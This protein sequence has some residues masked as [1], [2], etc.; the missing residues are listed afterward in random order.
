MHLLRFFSFQCFSHFCRLLHVAGRVA[1]VLDDSTLRI[2]PPLSTPAGLWHSSL[3]FLATASPPYF[4]IFRLRFLLACVAA[5]SSLP[6]FK[7]FGCYFLPRGT[8]L[9]AL[10]SSVESVLTLPLCARGSCHRALS[11]ASLVGKGMP[12]KPAVFC[13]Y[14][15]SLFVFSESRRP[16]ILRCG[17]FL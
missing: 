12:S 1:G 14:T 7:R 3:F 15:T 13:K 11:A 2:L 5:F 17:A 10:S 8:S 6:E 9:R 4:W 16:F